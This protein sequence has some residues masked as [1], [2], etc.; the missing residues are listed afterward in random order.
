LS[1]SAAD[2]LRLGVEDSWPPFAGADG[3]GLSTR[4]VKA[5][6][7]RVGREVDIN[8]YPYARVLHLVQAGELHGGYNV[9]RQHNTEQLFLFGKMP[10]LRAS[11][12]FFYRR[13][14]EKDYTHISQVPDGTRIG[15]I[16]DYEYGDAFEE[17]R[18][19][20]VEHRVTRQEQI[21]QLLL[22][23]RIDMAIMFD[24]VAAYTL[25]NM[26]ARNT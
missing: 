1:T 16:I 4:L 22:L 12:S 14:R 6:F 23:G 7:A 26:Q 13:G 10:L 20:F 24:K 9:T 17:H 8:V 19:R 2:R 5:A 25:A 3:D 18:H 11:T 21:I 15:L